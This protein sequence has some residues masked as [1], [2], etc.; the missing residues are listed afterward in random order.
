[1]LV[2]RMAAVA[3][4]FGSNRPARRASAYQPPAMVRH[5]QYGESVQ[6]GG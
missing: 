4:A 1:M 3:A 6:A 5:C 2:M